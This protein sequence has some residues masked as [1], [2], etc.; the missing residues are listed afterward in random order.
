MK[1][2]TLA[3]AACILS[4]T[5][6]GTFA[7]TDQPIS[8]VNETTIKNYLIGL[9]TNN[10]D[11]AITLTADDMLSNID[12][13]I[14]NGSIDSE[15]GIQLAAIVNKYSP[16]HTTIN[17]GVE[18]QYYNAKTGAVIIYTPMPN[19]HASLTMNQ[20]GYNIIKEIIAM[21]GGATVIGGSVCALV[22]AGVAATG[23]AITAI[24][25]SMLII[26]SSALALQFAFG[27]EYAV[28]G[29]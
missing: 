15:Y 27:N 1:I 9:E 25:G 14:S 3:L 6:I 10:F 7:S 20:A 12:L 22:G 24:I 8:K 23:G 19:G 2:K 13:A 18:A 21:G 17:G 26:E 16:S 28:C 11:S 5:S 29:W 4:T